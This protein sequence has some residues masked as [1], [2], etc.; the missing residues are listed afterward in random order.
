MELTG[1]TKDA[2]YL[3]AKKLPS[4]DLVALCSTNTEMRQLCMSEKFNPIW[5]QRLKTEYNIDYKGNDGYREYMLN[6]YCFNRTYWAAT[7]NNKG[8]ELVY[9]VILT[10]TKEEAIAKITETIISDSDYFPD[11]V[12]PA[13]NVSYLEIKLQFD[14]ADEM[15][16]GDFD[17]YLQKANFDLT[18]TINY[19]E[20]YQTKLNEVARRLFPQDEERQ[21]DFLGD[22]SDM[23]YDFIDNGVRPTGTLIVEKL[24]EDEMLETDPPQ[25]VYHLLDDLFSFK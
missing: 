2:K 1:L 21:K 18:P 17:I 14:Q 10:R 16:F 5:L 25:E 19:E 24:R 3:L 13:H 4:K 9:K 12:W 23:I 22:F 6:T 11:D 20:I 15:R 8:P 7:F